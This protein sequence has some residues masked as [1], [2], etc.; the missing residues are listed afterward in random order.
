MT[1]SANGSL[2][3]GIDLSFELSFGAYQ[4]VIDK[5]AYYI[6][7]DEIVYLSG[8]LI[9]CYELMKRKQSFIVRRI[10]D[11]DASAMACYSGKRSNNQQVSTVAVALKGSSKELPTVIVYE[12]N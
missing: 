1:S 2:F 5:N 9:V 12:K 11:S 3:N 4:T 10:E 6:G 8:K 7:D